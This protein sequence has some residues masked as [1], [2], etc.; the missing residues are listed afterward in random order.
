MYALPFGPKVGLASAWNHRVSGE[1]LLL[2]AR[3]KVAWLRSLAVWL[4]ALRI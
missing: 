1:G 4:P 2:E 3:G